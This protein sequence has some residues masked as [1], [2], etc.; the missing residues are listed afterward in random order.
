M[1]LSD[2]RNQRISNYRKTLD[3]SEAPHYVVRRYWGS[4]W[5]FAKVKNNR[6]SIKNQINQSFAELYAKHVNQLIGSINQSIAKL[7]AE[8]VNQLIGCT[9]TELVRTVWLSFS[10]TI[11]LIFRLRFLCLPR[12]KLWFIFFSSQIL[13]YDVQGRPATAAEFGLPRK[14]EAIF[15]GG[16]S[17]PRASRE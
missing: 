10:A 8:E 1:L 6:H 15:A 3:T 4:N 9:C 11:V 17:Q 13:H 16:T 2:F 5:N 7:Y 12:S 14:E